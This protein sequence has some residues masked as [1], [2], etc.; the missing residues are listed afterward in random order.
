L[1]S[2]RTLL[3][4]S[5]RELTDSA[6]FSPTWCVLKIKF[7]YLNLLTAL[8]RLLAEFKKPILKEEKDEDREG[9]GR[10]RK[11]WEREREELSPALAV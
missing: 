8:L 3:Q 6:S 1:I 2:A 9:K 7:T 5:L 11:Q 4:N 10:R